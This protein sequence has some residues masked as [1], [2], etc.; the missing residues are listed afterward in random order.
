MRQNVFT[1]HAASAGSSRASQRVATIPIPVP[2]QRP[3]LVF[4]PSVALD[5]K[6]WTVC[7]PQDV[8]VTYR[9]PSDWV[10]YGP[11]CSHL[12]PPW[13][14]VQSEDTS[15]FSLVP[16]LVYSDVANDPH[17]ELLASNNLFQLFRD[18][19]HLHTNGWEEY[20]LVAANQASPVV[21]FVNYARAF[22]LT[23][24]QVNEVNLVVS[25][26][27]ASAHPMDLSGNTCLPKT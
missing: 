8:G 1:R 15:V 19:G 10:V 14:E 18:S 12:N 4:Q 11:D 24:D 16:C 22:A 5:M 9:Y 21:G 23:P 26:I 13:E 20:Y 17:L 7:R 3:E 25:N 6:D 27:I 2:T